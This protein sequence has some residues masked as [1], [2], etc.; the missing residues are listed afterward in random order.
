MKNKKKKKKKINNLKKKI[1][2]HKD[3]DWN[4]STF[5]IFEVLIIILI[6]ILFGVI[7]GYIITCSKNPLNGNDKNLIELV[8]VYNN[9]TSNYY[10]SVDKNKLSDAAIKGMIESVEDPY[11]NYMDEDITNEFNESVRGSFVGIGVTVRYEDGYYKII[12]VMKD[13]PASKSDLKVDDI[14]VKV[15]G[16][17]IKEKPEVF[18]TISKGKVGSK[19][20]LTVKRNDKYIDVTLK[21]DIIELENVHNHI[22]DY[23]GLNIGYVKIDSFT[24]NSY[25]QFKKSIN[26]FGKNKIDALVIDV[27]DNPGG[28]LEQTREILSTFFTRKTIL[29]QVQIGKVTRKVHALNSS[30]K[31]YPIAVLTNAGSASAAEILASCF[32]ENYKNAILVGETTYGKGTVQKTQSLNSGNSIKYTTEKW[33]TSTGKWLDGKGVKPDI[34]VKG[35]KE[36]YEDPVYEKD[37]QLQEALKKLKE[38]N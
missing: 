15:N 3:D 25:K 34:E 21:R 2:R 14:L 29:Y 20:K 12:S 1:L 13:T 19:V 9:L 10:K 24:S 35:T 18:K 5:S 38:S 36:Y 4:T 28:Q 16:K 22:F 17:D 6:S 7:V 26:R 31:K 33:L 23:E 37:N 8:D 30:T 27:R 11:T 32:K